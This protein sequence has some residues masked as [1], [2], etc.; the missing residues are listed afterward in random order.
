M[1]RPNS[2]GNSSN[3]GAAIAREQTTPEAQPEQ[4]TPPEPQGDGNPE[5]PAT[6]Q[7]AAPPQDEPGPEDFARHSGAR[8]REEHARDLALLDDVERRIRARAD[9]IARRL[10]AAGP[11]ATIEI[12]GKTY[13][14][15]A[16]ARTGGEVMA[17]SEVRQRVAVSLD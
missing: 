7:D 5:N 13:E 2:R 11:G 3:N 8:L 14:A 17:L 4:A 1:A 16:K 10:Q 12:G 6:V 9:A 15:R